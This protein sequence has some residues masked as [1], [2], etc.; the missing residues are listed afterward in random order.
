[1]AQGKRPRAR[2]TMLI[3]APPHAVYR[4][5]MDPTSLS[6]F[7]LSSASGP[8]R[9][10]EPVEW[11]F[12]VAGATD[13]PVATRLIEG[14]HIAWRWSD[15]AVQID[16]EPFDDGTAITLIAEGFPG[17]PEAQAE[18]A[19][20]ATEGFCIVLCDLKTWLESGASAGLT[21]AKARLIDARG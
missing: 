9:V 21:R 19:L 7:W 12:M 11:C 18:A 8:L 16:L 15:G 3:K 14:E 17:D 10:G 13:R 5:F 6:A 1:M 20:N 4:A 2:V